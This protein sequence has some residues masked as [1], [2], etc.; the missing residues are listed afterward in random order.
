M[1]VVQKK[2]YNGK[3]RW[4]YVYNENGKKRE[5]TSVNPQKLKEKVLSKG[6]DW[7]ILDEKQAKENNLI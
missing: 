1:V 4:K 2:R 7:I 5:I 3:Y 6:F